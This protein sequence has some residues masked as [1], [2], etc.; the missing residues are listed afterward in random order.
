MLKMEEAR[1]VEEE[2]VER[3]KR[4]KTEVVRRDLNERVEAG[5]YMYNSGRA[6][7]PAATA[8]SIDP[9]DPKDSLTR[10]SLGGPA[11]PL[12][13]CRG[14]LFLLLYAPGGSGMTARWGYG[15]FFRPGHS[16]SDRSQTKG[17]DDTR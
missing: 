9:I 17:E 12:V 5:W 4:G 11:I 10:A 6:L 2:F 15:G 14:T 13:N 8:S 3:R 1:R 16:D 7:H